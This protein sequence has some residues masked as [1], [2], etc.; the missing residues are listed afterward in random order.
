MKEN[1]KGFGGLNPREKTPEESNRIQRHMKRA[2]K[3]LKIELDIDNLS[4]IEK[5]WLRAGIEETLRDEK[6]GIKVK[7]CE[8]ES[9]FRWLSNLY[10]IKYDDIPEEYVIE[11]VDTGE[12]T[13]FKSVDLDQAKRTVKELKEKGARVVLYSQVPRKFKDKLSIRRQNEHLM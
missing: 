9:I 2:E 11:N 4:D 1:F 7:N 10:L 13:R 6:D 12:E 3:L 5:R 8:T